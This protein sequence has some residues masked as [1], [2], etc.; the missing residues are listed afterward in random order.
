MRTDL[1]SEEGGNRISEA[2]RALWMSPSRL[3]LP[4]S[5]VSWCAADEYPIF[6]PNS[7]PASTPSG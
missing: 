4:C 5:C 1:V 6:P 2:A 7:S 3:Q